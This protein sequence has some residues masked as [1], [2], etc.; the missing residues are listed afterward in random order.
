[1]NPLIGTSPKETA[2]NATAAMSELMALLSKDAN[3]TGIEYLLMP[4][5]S[6]L[7]SIADDG[8]EK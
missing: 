4:I 5:A 2:Q 8:G 3:S 1:M 7:E 6:A